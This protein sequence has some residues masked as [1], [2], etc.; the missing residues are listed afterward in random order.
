[1]YICV[2]TL[3]L[4]NIYFNMKDSGHFDIC[5]FPFL[6]LTKWVLFVHLVWFADTLVC[7]PG[8]WGPLRALEAVALLIVKCVFFKKFN[9]YMWTHWKI[10]F[11]VSKILT[12]LSFIIGLGCRWGGIRHN[13]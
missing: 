5:N 2:G 3:D 9:L 7:K 8:V 1:M 10:S 6:C 4:Q 13:Q 12:N 11:S